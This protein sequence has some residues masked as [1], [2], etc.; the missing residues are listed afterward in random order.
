[1]LWRLSAN[2]QW[3]CC[4]IV[5]QPD[6]DVLIEWLKVICDLSVNW[7]VV[8]VNLVSR[9]DVVMHRLWTHV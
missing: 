5:H 6:C 9:L 1:M 3:A 8:V 2:W 4:L 7:L